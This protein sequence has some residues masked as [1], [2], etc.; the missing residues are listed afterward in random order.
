MTL[1][2]G[3]IKLIYH[4]TVILNWFLFAFI[5]MN[6]YL[7]N[8]KYDH[9]HQVTCNVTNV[10]IVQGYNNY[11]RSFVIEYKNIFKSYTE[12]VSNTNPQLNDKIICYYNDVNDDIYLVGI[13]YITPFFNIFV[14][15]MFLVTNKAFRTVYN[16][17]MET[18]TV[19]EP[20][21][22]GDGDSTDI[23]RVI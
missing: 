16:G 22:Q 2:L 6:I 12:T 3:R 4:L 17:Y 5:M 21:I 8:E 11:F 14:F 19:R 1:T 15:V 13:E 18:Y 9:Q 7:N 20:I 23:N 10:T